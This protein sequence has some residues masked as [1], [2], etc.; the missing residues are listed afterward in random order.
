LLFVQH[1]GQKTLLDVANGKAVCRMSQIFS[2][3]F[4]YKNANP[5]TL[6]KNQFFILCR[7]NINLF[8][9]LCIL[10]QIDLN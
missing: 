8:H 2:T 3:I 5:A 9:A 10:S 1:W 7:Q 4:C 6:F